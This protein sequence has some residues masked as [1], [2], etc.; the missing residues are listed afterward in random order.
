MGSGLRAHLPGSLGWDT[1]EPYALL[2]G[3]THLRD[4][5]PQPP[6]PVRRS[7]LLCPALTLSLRIWS[8][9]VPSPFRDIPQCPWLPDRPSACPL[10]DV[11]AGQR[12]SPAQPHSGGPWSGNTDCPPEPRMEGIP[13]EAKAPLFFSVQFSEEP[14]SIETDD[15]D[16]AP[17]YPCPL[18]PVPPTWVGPAPQAHACLHVGV[19]SWLQPRAG[20]VAAADY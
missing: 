7:P 3:L 19:S 4:R 2:P 11:F 14:R 16:Q 20:Q 1:P 5:V 13:K 17:R 18:V 15:N 12:G 8:T 9:W 6:H 10:P